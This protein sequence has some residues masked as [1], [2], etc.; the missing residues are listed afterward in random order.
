MSRRRSARVMRRD[1]GV[2]GF[3]TLSG[4]PVCTERVHDESSGSPLPPGTL[5][6]YRCKAV[7]VV[8][9]EPSATQPDR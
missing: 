8:T 2:M 5:E 6:K 4:T 1:L 7:R 3:S 9:P